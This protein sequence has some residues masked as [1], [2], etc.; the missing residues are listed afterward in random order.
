MLKLLQYL[1]NVHK[2]GQ[3]DMFINIL[4]RGLHRD[5]HNFDVVAKYRYVRYL[6]VSNTKF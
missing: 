5:D 4:L 2:S 1:V 3:L 6:F